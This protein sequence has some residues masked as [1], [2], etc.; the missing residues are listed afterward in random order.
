MSVA[1]IF[2]ASQ[3][4]NP[5][6]PATGEV[7]WSVIS[8]VVLLILLAKY[9][10]PPV[11]KIMEERTAKIRGDIEAAESARAEAERTLAQYRSQLEEGRQEASRI[12]EEARKTAAAI[13]EEHLQSALEEASEIKR[14]AEDALV[15]ERARVASELRKE[16]GDLAVAL[17]GR[18]LSLE[19]EKASYDP[20][21]EQFLLEVGAEKK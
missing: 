9:A 20:L 17:A 4:F 18:I 8:F 19:I 12:I 2:G 13:R 3:A 11:K 6:L 5:I 16:V 14:R 7:I 10:F 21:I 15:I 1:V